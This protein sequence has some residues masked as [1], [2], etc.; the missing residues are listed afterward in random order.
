MKSEIEIEINY[1]ILLKIP[2]F[3]TTNLRIVL[4]LNLGVGFRLDQT[5]KVAL[6]KTICS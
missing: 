4:R 2:K 3:H 6:S 1:A 5:K